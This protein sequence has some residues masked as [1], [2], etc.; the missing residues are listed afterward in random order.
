MIVFYIVQY[1]LLATRLIIHNF[2]S[3]TVR[4]CFMAGWYERHL[5]RALD[6]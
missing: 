3:R 2:S 4:I 5:I 1:C 6:Y